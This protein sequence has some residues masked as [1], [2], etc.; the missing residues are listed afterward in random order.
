MKMKKYFS[1]ITIS[2]LVSVKVISQTCIVILM[3]NRE[4]Y[5]GADS[6]V[7]TT[8]YMNKTEKIDTSFNECKISSINN[9]F[10]T[11]AGNRIINLAET[12]EQINPKI[13]IDSTAQL[14]KINGKSA[15]EAILNEIK[16]NSLYQFQNEYSLGKII[17]DIVICRFDKGK[18]KMYRF[19][20]QIVDT[21][22]IKVDCDSHSVS[23][24]SKTDVVYFSLGHTQCVSRPEM[25]YGKIIRKILI[26]KQKNKYLALLTMLEDQ[27]QYL[28]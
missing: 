21:A 28:S 19:R 2:L 9:L 18:P 17:S 7:P 8:K 16:R 3:N 20:F 27:F 4:I 15:L 14:F 6:K 10:Y 26:Q 5:I 1:F 13:S 23:P 11:G 12:L 25:S 24:N 22:S